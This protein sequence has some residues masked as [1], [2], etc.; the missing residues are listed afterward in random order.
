LRT[1]GHEFDENVIVF[2]PD[3]EEA[4]GDDA[5][6]MNLRSNEIGMLIDEK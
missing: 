4:Q 3:A 5:E 1:L 6:L 2:N